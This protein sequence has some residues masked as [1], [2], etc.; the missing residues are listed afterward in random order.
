[1]KVILRAD[2]TNIGRQGDVKTIADGFARNYLLPRKMVMEATEANLKLWNREKGKLE[3]Q[4]DVVISDALAV[5]MVKEMGIR[6]KEEEKKEVPVMSLAWRRQQ[7]E[8]GLKKQNDW[9]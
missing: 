3:K 6:E 5:K 8:A 4:R 7:Y 2:I 1:M 9:A